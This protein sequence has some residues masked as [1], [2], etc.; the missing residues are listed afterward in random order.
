MMLIEGIDHNAAPPHLK[1]H[2]LNHHLS[3]TFD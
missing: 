1:F 2:Y 3:V